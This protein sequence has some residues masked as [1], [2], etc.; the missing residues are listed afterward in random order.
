MTPLFGVGG[1][2]VDQDFEQKAV[3][4]RFGQRIRALELDRILR[5]DDQKH[6]RQRHALAL[7]RHLVLLHRFEQRG[8]G[9]GGGAIDLVGDDDVGEDRPAPET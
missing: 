7:D 6:G 4:L 8:L 5:G 1:A 3:E 2:V 9:L